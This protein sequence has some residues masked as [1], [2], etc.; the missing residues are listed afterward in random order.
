[1]P[2]TVNDSVTDC[3]C[4]NASDVSEKYTNNETTMTREERGK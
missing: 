4:L 3:P 2:G 1:M